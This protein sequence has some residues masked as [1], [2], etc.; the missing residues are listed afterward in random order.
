MEVSSG[1]KFYCPTLGV[2]AKYSI[3]TLKVLFMAVVTYVGF[4]KVIM[5]ILC[6]DLV[7]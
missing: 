4:K 5:I 3:R 2:V 7:I 1:V 6:T